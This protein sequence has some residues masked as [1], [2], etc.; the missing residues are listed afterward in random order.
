VLLPS[1][2]FRCCACPARLP[3]PGSRGV[4]PLADSRCRLFPCALPAP[5]WRLPQRLPAEV[6]GVVQRARPPATWGRAPSPVQAEQ[7]S[8]RFRRRNPRRMVWQSARGLGLEQLPPLHERG[9]GPGGYQIA[10]DSTKEGASRDLY[11]TRSSVPRKKP[12][13][14]QSL[15]GAPSRVRLQGVG[16]AIRQDFPALYSVCASALTCYSG[17]PNMAASSSFAN[18]GLAPP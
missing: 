13:P 6:R 9:A 8:A 11:G 15:D 1:P 17:L 3:L 10:G 16:R 12:P 14:K 5:H 4:N 7:G 18:L 2:P